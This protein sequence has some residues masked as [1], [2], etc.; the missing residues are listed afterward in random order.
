MRIA[1]SLGP[2]QSRYMG[3]APKSIARPPR[4]SHVRAVETKKS[5]RS[6]P[7]LRKQADRIVPV[8]QTLNRLTTVSTC[9]G[10]FE[11]NVETWGVPALGAGSSRG[12]RGAAGSAGTECAHE[13]AIGKAVTAVD[14]ATA[15]QVRAKLSS[16][17]FSYGLFSKLG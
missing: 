14:A 1:R 9:G 15:S 10:M 16:Q 7:P 13:K 2:R 8:R 3:A 12:A 5:R 17:F 4:S 11:P 6:W